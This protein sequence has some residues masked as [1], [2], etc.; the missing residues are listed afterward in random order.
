VTGAI[1]TGSKY[2]SLSPLRYGYRENL[3]SSLDQ[4]RPEFLRHFTGKP[5]GDRHLVIEVT[6]P[7][8]WVNNVTTPQIVETRNAQG[9]VGGQNEQGHF[10][11]HIFEERGSQ[12]NCSLQRTSLL[13]TICLQK[14]I[15]I[16]FNLRGFGNYVEHRI[17]TLRAR[18]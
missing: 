8:D 1:R 11:A 6:S 16:L 3:I 17:A 18:G 7:D 2:V 14:G 12:K 9:D 10:V 13:L 4:I 5:A 15:M